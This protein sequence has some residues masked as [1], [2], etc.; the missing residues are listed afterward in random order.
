MKLDQPAF[1]L[2]ELFPHWDAMGL[3]CEAVGILNNHHPSESLLDQRVTVTDTPKQ[4]VN[5]T[6][7]I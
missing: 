2:F 1:C 7:Y 4:R 5:Y 3:V 6:R